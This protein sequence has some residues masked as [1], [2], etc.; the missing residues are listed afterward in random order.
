MHVSHVSIR[1]YM[2]LLKLQPFTSKFVTHSYV[3]QTVLSQ[4]LRKVI[5]V[6]RHMYIYIYICTYHMFL[7]VIKTREPAIRYICVNK[8]VFV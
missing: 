1:T 7:P 3:S 4:Q 5:T 2:Y 6:L 8:Y